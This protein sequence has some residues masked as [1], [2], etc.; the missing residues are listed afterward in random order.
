MSRLGT[1][2]TGQRWHNP[3]SPDILRALPWE[4]GDGDVFISSAPSPTLGPLESSQSALRYL[5]ST[6]TDR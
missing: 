5:D 4:F 6:W 3:A 2:H 1:Q